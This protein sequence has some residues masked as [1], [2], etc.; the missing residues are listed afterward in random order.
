MSFRKLDANGRPLPRK[1]RSGRMPAERMENGRSVYH[2]EITCSRRRGDGTLLQIRRR[3]WLPDNEAAEALE[4]DLLR[5]PAAGSLSWTKA[6]QLWR[7]ANIGKRSPGH[8]VNVEATL[9]RW[10][11]VVGPKKGV[12]DTTLAEFSAWVETRATEGTGRA[13]QLDRGH[14]LTIA[15]WCRARGHITTVPFDHAP[16]PQDR[17]QT[18]TPAPLDHY[19]RVLGI[20]PQNM[21]LL[22]RLLALTGMRL[23][24]ACDLLE[25]DIGEERFVV[26]TKGSAA[27]GRTRVP[28][29][30]TPEIR[31]IVEE[32][33]TYKGGIGRAD[34]PYLFCNARGGRWTPKSFGKRL[35]DIIASW[36]KKNE[37]KRKDGV[38][39]IP[40]VISH[41]LR[42]MA[43]TVLGESDF[44]VPQ[45]MA[46]LGQTNPK[47]A[48]GYVEKTQ[49]MRDSGMEAVAK[50]LR[51]GDGERFGRLL[52]IDARILQET[53]MKSAES[54]DTQQTPEIPASARQLTILC[55]C[56]NRK[57]KLNIKITAQP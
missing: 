42:H 21:S 2:Y 14:L 1:G 17:M 28:Y 46:A 55:P 37:A 5:R 35:R 27:K 30:L 29:R 57:F 45:I 32:A 53:D 12:E 52:E 48:M 47:S 56:C 20:L 50:F 31:T 6:H 13:A 39:P 43:G 10:L 41:R 23:G 36:N 25:T 51:G 8:F 44:T 22:W 19:E 33:R 4:R 38:E 34:I 18:R 7:E 3:A 16:K 9:R 54:G 26:T 40:M 11:D 15:R 24:A 49:K